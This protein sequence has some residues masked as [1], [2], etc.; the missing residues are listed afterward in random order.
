MNIKNQIQAILDELDKKYPLDKHLWQSLKQ[1]EEETLGNEDFYETVCFIK[2]EY[3]TKFSL[4]KDQEL[5]LCLLQ[6]L[7]MAVFQPN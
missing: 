2:N 1:K 5:F 4:K 3:E 7:A 6:H